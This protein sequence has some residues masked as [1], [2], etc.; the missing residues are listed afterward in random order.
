VIAVPA[1]LVVVSIGVTEPEL[2]LATPAVLPSGVIATAP[3]SLQ[4]GIA[5]PAM[6]MARSIGVTEPS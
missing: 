6:S 3:G 1:V 5:V 2:E 4:T